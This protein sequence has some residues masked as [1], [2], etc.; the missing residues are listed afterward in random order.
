M[1]PFFFRCF[2]IFHGFSHSSP[3]VFIFFSIFS[4]DF[5]I[6][7]IC[8]MDFPW[9]Q[10]DVST[11]FGFKNGAHRRLAQPP[12]MLHSQDVAG[13]RPGHL[14]EVPQGLP[15]TTW[16]TPGRNED[17]QYMCIMM[18]WLL[19]DNAGY[20]WLILVINGY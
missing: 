3:Y 17:L 19:M 12:R 10:R 14:G 2:H 5:P 11:I 20:Q 13:I 15:E 9:F 18:M 1:F 16:K 7:S 4:M 6:F 8:S